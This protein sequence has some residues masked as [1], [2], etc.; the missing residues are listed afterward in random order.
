MKRPSPPGCPPTNVSG[1]AGPSASLVVWR[2]AQVWAAPE[3]RGRWC[4]HIRSCMPRCSAPIC[5][6]AMQVFGHSTAHAPLCAAS[7]PPVLPQCV[8]LGSV[9][10]W[11]V[12]RARQ[13]IRFC[14]RDPGN[15]RCSQLRPCF[16]ASH[17]DLCDA[18]PHS[19]SSQQTIGEWPRLQPNCVATHA[20]LSV[21]P[22]SCGACAG[23]CPTPARAR[24][25]RSRHLARP[26]R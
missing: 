15:F 20:R 10:P 4:R 26:L 11:T 12:A 25:A 1:P 3:Y 13:S 14:T 2:V 5:H 18:P 22:R 23:C 9:R 16:V 17:R 19:S 8:S 6:C 24:R 21:H 7:S